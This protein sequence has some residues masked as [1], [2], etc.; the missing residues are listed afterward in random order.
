M[1]GNAVRVSFLL[2]AV[3]LPTMLIQ[4]VFSEQEGTYRSAGVQGTRAVTV[5][6]D[7]LHSAEWQTKADEAALAAVKAEIAQVEAEILQEQLRLAAQ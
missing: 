1:T 2:A 3:I 6:Y 4:R 5:K 7:M